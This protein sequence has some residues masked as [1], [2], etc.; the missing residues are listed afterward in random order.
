MFLS[1]DRPKRDHEKTETTSTAPLSV[2][3]S[4]SSGGSNHKYLHKARVSPAGNESSARSDVKSDPEALVGAPGGLNDQ[5]QGGCSQL[6]ALSPRGNGEPG[7]SEAASGPGRNRDHRLGLCSQMLRKG[8]ARTEIATSAPAAA[9]KVQEPPSSAEQDGSDARALLSQPFPDDDL[10]N[11]KPE[12]ISLSDAVRMAA[13]YRRLSRLRH[14]D[15][16]MLCSAVVSLLLMLVSEHMDKG[17]V[18]LAMEACNSA[19]TIFMLVSAGRYHYLHRKVA[20]SNLS[21]SDES[22]KSAKLMKARLLIMFVLECAVLL[23]HPAP[24]LEMPR[25]VALLM[26][27]RLYLALRVLR[28]WSTQKMRNTASRAG[29]LW[30]NHRVL[31]AVVSAASIQPTSLVTEVPS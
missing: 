5:Q 30:D 11:P 13:L 23:P 20:L 29:P 22:R 3:K 25:E 15:Y 10:D 12:R 4:N 6:L 21:A 14:L 9:V 16:A 2:M 24:G 31:M 7:A 27:L 18:R 1:C 28:D 26:F 19:I 8:G 17:T